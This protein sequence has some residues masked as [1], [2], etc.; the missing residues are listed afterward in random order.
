MN[1]RPQSP[2]HPTSPAREPHG[3]PGEFAYPHGSRLAF[4]GGV[5][6][7]HIALRAMLEDA[8]Q[9]GARAAFCLGDL[10]GFGPSP[11]KVFPLLRAARVQA[12]RGNYDDSVGNERPD[13]ACGYTDPRDQHFAQIS[14][15]YTAARTSQRDKAW[16][17]RLPEQLRLRVGGRAA[18]LCH[19]SPRRMNEFLWDS[20]CST[21]FLE[22]LAASRNAD[23]VLCTH[24]G[25]HW[26]RP[27]P[28]GRHFI[29]V[30]SVGRPAN[31]GRT[32]VWY[33]M[34][35]FGDV[36]AVEFRP[37]AYDYEELAREMRSEGL[38]QEF[39]E[40]VRTGWWTCCLE[41]LPALER[42][43]GRH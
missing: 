26:H 23:I 30:G 8:N 35:E 39:V 33:A 17:R 6:S 20:T 40:T 1:T 22:W 29:N 25:I 43:R 19:G 7:N 14:F 2:P 28:S 24:T 41:N 15:D 12:L 4:F 36:V 42:L 37:V 11:A 9:A 18:L 5:Y 16:L 21:A 27:L 31:D 13:C 34:V 10:G 3:G 32:E 38:P